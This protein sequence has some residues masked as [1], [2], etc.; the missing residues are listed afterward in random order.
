MPFTN[1]DFS[2]IWNLSLVAAEN[3]APRGTGL[4]TMAGPPK[5]RESLYLSSPMSDIITLVGLTTERHRWLF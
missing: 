4:L 3:L 1:P 5:R 2:E